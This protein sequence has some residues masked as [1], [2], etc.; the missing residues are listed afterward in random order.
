MPQKL[1]IAALGRRPRQTR[2][3]PPLSPPLY[4]SRVVFLAG[5]ASLQRTCADGTTGLGQTQARTI[6]ALLRPGRDPGCCVLSVF[7][8]LS[9]RTV[10]ALRRA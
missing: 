6:T 3:L 4:K 8:V 2:L 1:R 9:G 5:I 10:L 7:C